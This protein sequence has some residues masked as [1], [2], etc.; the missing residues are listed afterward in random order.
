LYAWYLSLVVAAE[1][2][3]QS[4]VRSRYLLSLAAAVRCANTVART[5]SDRSV[6]SK[7]HVNN[8]III[9]VHFAPPLEQLLS[10]LS[11]NRASTTALV[12]R[13]NKINIH[14]TFSTTTAAALVTFFDRNFD[15]QISRLRL[16]YLPEPNTSVYAPDHRFDCRRHTITYNYTAIIIILFLS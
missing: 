8:N 9:V 14:R 2:E 12:S 10:L 1:A 3:G 16:R 15:S 13:I 5:I 11:I 4:R 6:S 7:I